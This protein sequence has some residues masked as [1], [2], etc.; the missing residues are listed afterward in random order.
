MPPGGGWLWEA[1]RREPWAGG[2][3]SADPFEKTRTETCCE[4]SGAG[5]TLTNIDLSIDNKTQTFTKTYI[6][7]KGMSIFCKIKCKRPSSGLGVNKT[8]TTAI[9]INKY[10]DY[11]YHLYYY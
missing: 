6:R 10:V 5:Q 9:Y 2:G 11:L 4:K 1:T 3:K 8:Y 7:Q